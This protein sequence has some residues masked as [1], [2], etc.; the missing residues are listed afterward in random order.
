MRIILRLPL[1]L[2]LL[3]LQEARL[4]RL[5]LCETIATKVSMSIPSSNVMSEQ[6]INDVLTL[7]GDMKASITAVVK[8]YLN[9]NKSKVDTTSATT[10]YLLPTTPTTLY[11]YY[12]YFRC[13]LLVAFVQHSSF[14]FVLDSVGLVSIRVRLVSNW[15]QISVDLV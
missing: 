11:H 5:V 10:Y 7:N 15:L 9:K 3:L 4:G 14:D 2:P 12:Y 1:P 8:A 13:K 6:D